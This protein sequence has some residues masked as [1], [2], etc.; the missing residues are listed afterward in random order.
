MSGHKRTKYRKSQGAE[1]HDEHARRERN[2]R[3]ANVNES[4]RQ[5]S[6]IGG[7]ALAVCGLLRGSLSGLA[8][9]AIGGALIYRGVTGHCHLYEALD[10]SSAED[11]ENK[12]IT[13]QQGGPQTQPHEHESQ[14]TR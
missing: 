10:Y 4:E 8:L 1:H 11:G 2:F 9:A 7:T 12:Q 14:S 6:L 5:F 13:G 3:D